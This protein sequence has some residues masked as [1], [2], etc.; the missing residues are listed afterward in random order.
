MS[1]PT[2]ETDTPRTEYE[3]FYAYTMVGEWDEKRHEVVDVSFARDLERENAALRAAL[4]EEKKRWKLL[5]SSLF[6]LHHFGY[7]LQGGSPNELRNRVDAELKARALSR[8]EEG[9]G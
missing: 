9:E 2:P 5:E 6:Q 8:R 1:T 7:F 4:E 3:A